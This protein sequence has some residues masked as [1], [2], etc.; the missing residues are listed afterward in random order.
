MWEINLC[1]SGGLGWL[2][3]ININKKN[4]NLK[5]KKIIKGKGKKVSFFNFCKITNIV[6]R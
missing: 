5:L 2:T 3:L 4:N 1:E 6:E